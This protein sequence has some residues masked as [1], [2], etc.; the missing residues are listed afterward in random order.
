MTRP[1]R[2][3]RS[4]SLVRLEVRPINVYSVTAVTYWI[5]LLISWLLIES[6]VLFVFPLMF[7]LDVKKGLE[8]DYTFFHT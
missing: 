7:K 8:P 4:S 5:H 1:S 3:S 2:H 6:P